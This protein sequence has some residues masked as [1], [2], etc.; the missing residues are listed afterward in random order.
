MAVV[1]SQPLHDTWVKTCVCVH[2][3]QSAHKCTHKYALWKAPH[4]PT[5]NSETQWMTWKKTLWASTNY[6]KYENL[7]CE[8]SVSIRGALAFPL[9]RTFTFTTILGLSIALQQGAAIN[10]NKQKKR[11]GGRHKKKCLSHSALETYSG[12]RSQKFR[13]E[14]L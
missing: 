13:Q 5:T 3:S 2:I 10:R 14:R 8:A 4:L 12:W 9:P 7:K 11:G 1:A 6:A